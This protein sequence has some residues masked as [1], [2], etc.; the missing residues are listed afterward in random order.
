MGKIIPIKLLLSVFFSFCSLDINECTRGMSNCHSLAT[1]INI[2]GSYRCRCNPGY[3][4]NGR[5]CRGSLAIF[6]SCLSSLNKI[7]AFKRI[8]Y[9]KFLFECDCICMSLCV[10][11]CVCMR[12]C[13]RVC[14]RVC[15]SVCER[16][17]VCVSVWVCVPVRV[18]IGIIILPQ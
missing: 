5:N 16:E 12:V 2:P 6:F 18:C 4:G 15:V 11:M 8:M 17:R 1:C 9:N 7:K 13:L 14:A 3:Q 10:C